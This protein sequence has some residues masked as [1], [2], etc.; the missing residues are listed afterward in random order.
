MNG[1]NE[2]SF[3]SCGQEKMIYFA[4]SGVGGCCGNLKTSLTPHLGNYGPS[5]AI[6]IDEL[7]DAKRA[8]LAAVRRGEVP[9]A[10]RECP[11]WQLHDSPGDTLR[12][13][14]TGR[15]AC[16]KD[17]TTYPR[18][19]LPRTW[20]RRGAEATMRPPKKAR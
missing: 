4:A 6:D 5:G 2:S 13:S 7:A 12:C 19:A 1:Q 11:S 8:H 18:S 20:T 14:G 17:R 3:W 15:T 10:C 16:A 9:E